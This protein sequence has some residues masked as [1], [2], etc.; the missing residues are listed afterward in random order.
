[1]ETTDPVDVLS[2]DVVS[3]PPPAGLGFLALGTTVSSHLLVFL[4][5]DTSEMRG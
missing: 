3:H 5:R 4:V 1:M 2:E